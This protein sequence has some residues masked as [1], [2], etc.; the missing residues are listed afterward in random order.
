P[1]TPA[2]PTAA[3]PD[4]T[5]GA[6]SGDATGPAD[7][8]APRARQRRAGSRPARSGRPGA[9]R[10]PMEDLR[11]ALAQAIQAGRIDPRPSA[12]AI[13]KLL[14]CSPTRARQLRDA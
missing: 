13:R 8:A 14:A 3:A 10:R 9:G 4:A 11:A 2:P 7:Q 6:P 1:S 5:D 12:E